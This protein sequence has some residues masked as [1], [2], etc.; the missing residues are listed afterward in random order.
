LNDTRYIEN[1]KP[2]GKVWN[3]PLPIIYTGLYNPTALSGLVNETDLGKRF[4]AIRESCDLMIFSQNKHGWDFYGNEILI[5]AVS[6]AIRIKPL[7]SIKIVVFKFGWDA[8]RSGALIKELNLESYFEWMPMMPRK[9]LM[10]GLNMSDLGIN[11]LVYGAFMAGSIFEC[12]ALGVPLIQYRKDEQH[13]QLFPELPSIIN[14]NS[15]EEIARHIIRFSENRQEYA[16]IGKEAMNWYNKYVVGES[17]SKI[18]STIE[19]KRN[20]FGH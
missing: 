1:L 2:Q 5:R 13:S 11:E 15:A 7:L 18:A 4:K 19:S 14:T 12:M 8:E 9:E 17:L 16:Q 10:F 6:L 20:G 3:I